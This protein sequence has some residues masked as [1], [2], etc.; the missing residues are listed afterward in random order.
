MLAWICN[1]LF[2]SASDALCA[3]SR[4]FEDCV[5]HCDVLRTDDARRLAIFRGTYYNTAQSCNP[6]E[7]YQGQ[8]HV[9]MRI[10][11]S[12]RACSRDAPTPRPSSAP[13]AYACS[14]ASCICCCSLSL[15]RLPAWDAACAGSRLLR[16]RGQLW[17]QQ[18]GVC[19]LG[20][21]TAF[22]GLPLLSGA[23]FGCSFFTIVRRYFINKSKKNSDYAE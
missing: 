5:A 18:I 16:E 17:G 20:C 13:S 3:C 10:S 2:P 8:G 15:P 7:D 11:A 23:Q 22:S 21:W 12:T 6:M 9:S 1:S 14:P 4:Q 19:L